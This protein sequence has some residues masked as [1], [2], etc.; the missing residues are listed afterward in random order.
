MFKQNNEVPAGV[1]LLVYVYYRMSSDQQDTSIEQQEIECRAY[2]A[3]R[4]WVIVAEYIDRGKSGSKDTSKRVEFWR[5]VKDSATRQ[6]NA[7]LCWDSA[8]FGR[9]DVIDSGEAGVAEL[10]RNGIHLETVKEGKI[11]WSTDMGVFQYAMLAGGNKGYSTKISG[12][13]VRGRN[14]VLK[15]GWWPNGSIP[16]GYDAEYHLDG[17]VTRLGRNERRGRPFKARMKLV[18]NAD[19]KNILKWMYDEI[20]N[21]G[22]SMRQ[23]AVRLNLKGIKAPHGGRSGWVN[24]NVRET[25]ANRAH[26]GDTCQGDERKRR[27]KTAWNRTMKAV[28]E[29][30]HEAIIEKDLWNRVQEILAEKRAG[31]QRIHTGLSGALS[32]I[33]VCGHCGFKM[34]K[35]ERKKTLPNGLVDRRVIYVC[36]SPRKRAHIGCKSYACHETE[37][38]PVLI[39]ELALAVDME[40][41]KT[42]EAKPEVIK[43]VK[44]EVE[45]LKKKLMKVEKDLANATRNMAVADPELFASI[46]DAVRDLKANRDRMKNT[47]TMLEQAGQPGGLEDVVSWY[48]RVKNRLVNVKAMRWVNPHLERQP[49]SLSSSHREELERKLDRRSAPQVKDGDTLYECDTNGVWWKVV[50][51]VSPEPGVMADA[52]VVRTMLHTLRCSLTLTWTPNGVRHHKL[53]SGIIRAVVDGN[54]FE[55]P[56]KQALSKRKGEVSLCDT[57]NR[58]SHGYNPC[59]G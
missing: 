15:N 47:V 23:L 17:K 49:V 5:M 6:V 25:L 4:G 2:A 18:P 34:A 8:R 12:N 31:G 52:D 56:V 44:V 10:R 42:V 14:D 13:T 57:S 53:D 48:N 26:I 38:L 7:I 32:G 36:Q 40:I 20:G 54:T 3:Q 28:N 35:A 39:D 24:Q 29:G 30:T 33:L 43:S 55:T 58:C 27:S 41:L 59:M 37:L 21:N 16:F 19:E 50:E 11:D 51:M 46:Q 45:G 1:K 22:V 9:L